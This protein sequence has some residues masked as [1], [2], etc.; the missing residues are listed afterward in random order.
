MARLGREIVMGYELHR[1]HKALL[2]AADADGCVRADAAGAIADELEIDDVGALNALWELRL[3]ELEWNRRVVRVYADPQPSN[4]AIDTSI[5][6]AELPA[7][8]AQL[9][10]D[11]I[12]SV[13]RWNDAGK[14]RSLCVA[15]VAAANAL[16]ALHP[17]AE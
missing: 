5:A 9:A 4:A 13:V 8:Q 6:W 14:H 16:R 2:A 15:L 12:R 1:F 7:E 3:A 10:L 11:E 17:E